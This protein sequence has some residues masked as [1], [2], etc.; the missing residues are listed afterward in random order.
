MKK[1]FQYTFYLFTAFASVCLM[2]CSDSDDYAKN[3][4]GATPVVNYIKECLI[5]PNDEH[6]ERAHPGTT[7]CI[8][9]QRLGDVRQVWFNDQQCRLNPNFV[10]SN[11]IFCTIPTTFPGK[12][13]NQIRLVTSTD[14]EV[15]VPFEVIIPGPS[16]KTMSLEY[17]PAGSQVTLTG[18]YFMEGMTVTF[19]ENAKAEII[20][21]TQT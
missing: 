3:D 14:K 16:L 5:E 20:K 10:T 19:H 15:S 12:V 18:D 9:G 17:A 13:T 2:S 11:D 4:K 1:I 8:V 21:L 6:I 7:L